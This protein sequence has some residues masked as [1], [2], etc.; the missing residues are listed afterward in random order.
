M[1]RHSRDEA[2]TDPLTGLRNR[3]S[4]MADLEEELPVASASY[5]R[6]LVLFDLDGF[7]E[8]NDAFGHPA[9][10][11]LLVRL[12][13]AAGRRGA[14]PRARL[15]ARRRRVLRAARARRGRLG[16]ARGRLRGRAARARRGLRG[17]HLARSGAG[18]RRG[19]ERHRGA[20]DRRSA[21]VRPQG[22]A[23]H[24][25]RPPVARRAAANAVRAPARAARPPARHRRAG[26]GRGSR[27]G[28]GR[29]GARRGGARG[30]A[31]RPRA[32]WPSRTRSSPSPARWTRPSGASCAATR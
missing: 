31:A 30:R 32:R 1:I 15:P 2:L 14:R 25:G 8:Y 22:R 4:L 3:R 10:D 23:A 28:D 6:A 19:H 13:R 12:G 17:D 7:K 21:H 24:V 5:P 9:G 20:A 26:A 27:A 11:G 18:S 16:P 29:R